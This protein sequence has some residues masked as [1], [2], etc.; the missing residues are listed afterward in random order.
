MSYQSVPAT[1]WAQWTEDNGALILDVRQ[2]KEWALGTLPDATLLSMHDI[3]AR[4]GE[5][6]KDQ[7]ILCV[8]RSGDRSGQVAAFLAQNGYES[9]ANM[10]GGMKALGMQS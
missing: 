5:L 7:A 3:P 10:T 6:P 2:P 9:V 8:C 4:L 1:D